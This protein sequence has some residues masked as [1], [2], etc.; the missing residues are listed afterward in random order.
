MSSRGAKTEV[1]FDVLAA[2]PP[3]RRLALQ[4]WFPLGLAVV[5]LLFLVSLLGIGIAGTPVGNRNALVV[6]VWIL[7]WFLLIA[8]LLPLASRAW[9]AACPI[10]FFGDW[11]QRRTLL[12]VRVRGAADAGGHGVVIGHNRY[13]GFGRRWPR[14]LSNLW[15]QSAGFL[16]LA[17]FSAVLLTNPLATAVTLGGMVI[18]ATGI[19]VVF[20]QRTFCRFLCPVGGFLSLYSMP[21]PVAVRARDRAVCTNCRQKACLAGNERGWGCP[22]LEYPSRLERN[23]AC[24]LC[25][26][27]LKTCPHDNMSL[28]LRP[29]FSERRL[30]GYDEVWKA[31]LMLALA[32]AYS[33]VYLGPWG[34][35]K[36]AANIAES[37]NWPAFLAYAGALWGVALGVVPGRRGAWR[38]RAP[39]PSCHSACSPGSPS[40]CRCSWPTVRMSLRRH[41]TPWAGA[42]TSSAPPDSLGR[43]SSL[44]GRR[45]SRRGWCWPVRQPAC[46]AAGS[47]R[48]PPTAGSGERSSPLRRP[49]SWS[50]WPR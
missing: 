39:R 31:Y 6:F 3:L 45:G 21:A 27:C 32:L 29:P 34:A 2:L 24:G 44:T 5:M 30:E 20:R 41:P 11:L 16:L 50:R 36:D 33:A 4:R 49:P 18:A 38:W 37:G 22:W 23:N 17:T 48:A 12:G 13:F 1:G 8:V 15:P 26:E 42:G 35:L 47:R 10:P 43:P 7:W 14:A 28:F 46:E 25:L 9:C 40:A 19:A